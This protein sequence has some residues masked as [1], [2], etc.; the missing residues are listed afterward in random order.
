M[1][2]LDFYGIYSSSRLVSSRET[3][4]TRRKMYERRTI[5]W[6]ILGEKLFYLNEYFNYSQKILFVWIRVQE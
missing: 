3:A 1:D 6:N 4:E 5:S 2:T